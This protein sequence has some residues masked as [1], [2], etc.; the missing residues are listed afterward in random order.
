MR[1]CG[2][3]AGLLCRVFTNVLR[4]INPSCSLHPLSLF[5]EGTGR[6]HTVPRQ[7][8]SKRYISFGLVLKSLFQ[9]TPFKW[10]IL[11]T[12]VNSVLIPFRMELE[13]SVVPE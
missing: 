11:T 2:S 4:R 12:N 1:V 13:F 9:W 6:R 8:G 10:F 5:G 3:G 7:T